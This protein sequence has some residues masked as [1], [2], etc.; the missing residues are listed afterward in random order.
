MA[1]TFED[2]KKVNKDIKTKPIKGKDYAEVNERITAFRKLFPEGFITTNV[3]SHENG[4]IVMGASCGYYAEDGSMHILGTGTA[5]EKAGSSQINNTSYIENCETSAVG[6]ALGMAGFGLVAS[7]ATAEEVANAIYQQN[8]PT[9]NTAPQAANTAPSKKGYKCA[10]CGGLEYDVDLAKA[11]KEKWG[12]IVCRKC[13][14]AKKKEYEAQMAAQ[15]AAPVA[16]PE[17]VPPMEIPEDVPLPF[18]LE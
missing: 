8:N 5:Y 3:I 17:P 10:V 7:I 14:T 9:P 18:P 15:Q 13:I 2:L 12:K 1:I 16:D 6:R 4:L 11:S